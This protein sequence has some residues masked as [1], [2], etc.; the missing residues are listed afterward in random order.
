MFDA[1]NT[2]QDNYD[3]QILVSVIIVLTRL[4]QFKQATKR[5]RIKRTSKFAQVCSLSLFVRSVAAVATTTKMMVVVVVVVGG[6][7]QEFTCFLYSK[8]FRP[9]SSFHDELL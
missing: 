2:V 6:G 3:H 5:T 4:R 9:F 7:G 1:L 8:I